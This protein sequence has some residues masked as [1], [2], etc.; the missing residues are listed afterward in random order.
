M[1]PIKDRMTEHCYPI[2]KVDY[3][4]SGR[5]NMLAEITWTLENGRFSMSAGIWNTSKTDYITCGQCVDTVAAF[6][7]HNARVQRML[8]VWREWHLNEM[9]AGSP[10]QM[11]WLNANPITALY[12]KSHYA[13]A[14]EALTSAGLNPDPNYL[15]NG[16]PYAYGSAWLKTTL[17]ADIIT[18]IESWSV[19]DIVTA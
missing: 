9:I 11:A 4:N 17:P 1:Y 3:N 8:A 12:P 7:P 10:A 2:A 16:K 13:K 5:K 19:S 14:S 6:F 18:E 15:H